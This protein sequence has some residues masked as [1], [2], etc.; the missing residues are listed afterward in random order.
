VSI[1]G[2]CTFDD[3]VCVSVS[4][5]GDVLFLCVVVVVVVV[6]VWHARLQPAIRER[7]L[8][9]FGINS[10]KIP[11][12]ASFP[13]PTTH[14]KPSFIPSLPQ[15]SSSSH[16]LDNA[17]STGFKFWILS[18]SILCSFEDIAPIILFVMKS[19]DSTPPLP[20]KRI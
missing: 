13:S 9:T 4:S 3:V 7:V 20:A 8:V 18:K 19:I 2:L 10:G 12:S 1:I 14:H 17:Q 11:F 6:V 15:P 5:N 16:H